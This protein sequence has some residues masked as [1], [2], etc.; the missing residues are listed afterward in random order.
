[1]SPDSPDSN[2]KFVTI[3]TN[4]KCP[5]KTLNHLWSQPLYLGKQPWITKGSDLK[6]SH[7]YLWIELFLLSS[8]E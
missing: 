6:T 5:N 2:M 3:K 4:I 1:M 7:F 8:P